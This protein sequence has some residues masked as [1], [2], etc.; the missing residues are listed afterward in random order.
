MLVIKTKVD[1]EVAAAIKKLEN[2]KWGLI[3]ARMKEDGTDTYKSAA[4]QN[5]FGQLQKK[6]LID[7]KGN[8]I[9][10]D[11]A[12]SIKTASEE[13]ENL[14]VEPDAEGENEMAED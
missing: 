12:N 10:A 11:A 3:A 2:E 13:L 8:Y 1:A 7:A 4:V 9:G 5:K 6:G 14:Q